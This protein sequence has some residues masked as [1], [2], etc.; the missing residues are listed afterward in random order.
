LNT[1]ASLVKHQRA[2]V[3]LELPKLRSTR[4]SKL[5]YPKKHNKMRLLTQISPK[6]LNQM[7]LLT[8]MLSKAPLQMEI[9][10]LKANWCAQMEQKMQKNSLSGLFHHRTL[11]PA[12]TVQLLTTTR[13]HKKSPPKEAQYK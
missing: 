4:Q 10:R 3:L 6:K 13:P 2:K 9:L 11:L 1:Q 7:R 5:T 8:Q 12:M